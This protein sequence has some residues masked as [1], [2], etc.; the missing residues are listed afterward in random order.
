MK[1]HALHPVHDN[2]VEHVAANFGLTAQGRFARVAL[3]VETILRRAIV[4]LQVVGQGEGRVLLLSRQKQ[5][6][7]ESMSRAPRWKHSQ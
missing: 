6:T 5:Y 1:A 2:A 7:R 4:L 3:E